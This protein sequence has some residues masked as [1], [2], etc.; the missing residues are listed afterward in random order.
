MK[1]NVIMQVHYNQYD[2]HSTLNPKQDYY[3][4]WVNHKV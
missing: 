4:Y 1:G 2:L 3:Y